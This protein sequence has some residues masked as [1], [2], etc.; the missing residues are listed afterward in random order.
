MVESE[1]ADFTEVNSYYNFR[2][3]DLST[4]KSFTLEAK[5]SVLKPSSN[6]PSKITTTSEMAESEALQAF[7]SNLSANLPESFHSLP[8]SN[9]VDFKNSV[10]RSERATENRTCS[11][12]TDRDEEC[13][14]CME[15][16]LQDP[17]VRI[18]PCGHQFHSKCVHVG[19]ITHSSPLA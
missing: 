17:D 14:I 11:E 4:L 16:L 12:D 9:S 5:P 10:Q 7:S 3:P 8:S 19:S 13:S 1:G 2:E 6:H 15:S 18:L